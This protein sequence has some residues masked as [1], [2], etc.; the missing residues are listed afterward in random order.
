MYHHNQITTK[1]VITLSVLLLSIT[2]IGLSYS[3]TAKIN[4]NSVFSNPQALLSIQFK[5]NI[6]M[7]NIIENVLPKNSEIKNRY[8]V[9][10]INGLTKVGNE[11]QLISVLGEYSPKQAKREFKRELSNYLA[12]LD[13][14]KSTG[15]E[16]LKVKQ[17]NNTT[18]DLNQTVHY[19]EQ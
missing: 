5:D 6:Y 11:E 4:D 19:L 12:K 3:S 2:T 9:T 1:L 16:N 17:E 10:S 7:D 15:T 8:G 18:K 13:T 14:I